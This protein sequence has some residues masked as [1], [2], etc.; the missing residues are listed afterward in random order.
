MNWRRPVFMRGSGLSLRTRTRAKARDT[1][2]KA[3]DYTE[4]T[5]F[6]T[7]CSR[8][9]QPAWALARVHSRMSVPPL[10][11]RL[12]SLVAEAVSTRGGK[13]DCNAGHDS[14]VENEA[15]ADEPG[16]GRDFNNGSPDEPAGRHCSPR[17][18]DV[19]QTVNKIR[20]G[21]YGHQGFDPGRRRCQRE[22]GAAQEIERHDQEVHDHLK[23]LHG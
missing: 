20:E 16:S 11:V 10:Y 14:Q 22:H 17:E 2:A 8:G 21:I 7:T 3:R 9:L 12:F 5:T 6:G 23:S 15:P 1:R 13:Q 18:E 19:A 4:A